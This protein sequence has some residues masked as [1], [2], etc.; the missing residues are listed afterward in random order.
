MNFR[1]T[2]PD[3]VEKLNPPSG[4]DC[5]HLLVRADGSLG[6]MTESGEFILSFQ[7]K[8]W[9]NINRICE[10]A[11]NMETGGIL[12]GYYSEDGT[13]AIVTETT[14]PP[15]DSSY[16]PTWFRRGFAG[17]RMILTQRWNG[18]R[19]QYY[20]GEWHYHPREVVALSALDMVRM[21]RIS[22]NP[23]YQCCEP[24][25]VIVGQVVGDLQLI[26]AFVFPNGRPPDEFRF[27]GL[28][29]AGLTHASGSRI[30]EVE[31]PSLT[32]IAKESE[33]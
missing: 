18:E 31:A 6:G 10:N 7:K 4:E 19:R 11:G 25:M 1:K 15:R 29:D 12:I 14:G 32:G 26:R 16:G 33:K 27:L 17:L 2:I 3:L 22:E 9:A 21:K 30:S 28:S 13:T 5:T 23:R 8:P 20:L 24:I